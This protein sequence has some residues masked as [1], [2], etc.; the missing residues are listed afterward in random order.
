MRV[1]TSQALSTLPFSITITITM[2]FDHASIVA[3]CEN[4]NRECITH[5]VGDDSR[6]V[7]VLNQELVV[8]NGWHVTAEEFRNQQYAYQHFNCDELRIPRA[9]EFFEHNDTGYLVMERMSGFRCVSVDIED[10]VRTT[11]QALH[12]M[13]SLPAPDNDAAGPVGGGYCPLRFE[14]DVRFENKQDL[15]DFLNA[16]LLRNQK[17]R[18][19]FNLKDENLVFAHLDVAP[20]N[21]GRLC[22]GAL[23]ILDWAIAGFYPRWFEIAMLRGCHDPAPGSNQ[24]K[25]ALVLALNASSS[26][27]PLEDLY[28][29]SLTVVMY[30][31]VAKH[32]YV[33]D[34]DPAVSN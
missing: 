16:R 5:S 32:L 4:P 15:E 11:A 20:R 17:P 10:D 26:L 24:F 9:I 1:S 2:A 31:C 23:C 29:E 13:H 34:G 33:I 19:L 25:D 12:R 18:R 21:V 3:R 27:T 6:H 28:A 14:D 30:N 8:K 22:N 7:V